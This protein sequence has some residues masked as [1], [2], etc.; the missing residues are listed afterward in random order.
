ME[1]NTKNRGF[2][3]TKWVRIP[4]AGTIEIMDYKFCP[5]C[6]DNLKIKSIDSEQ[7]PV[8]ESCGFVFYQ[9]SKPTASA[10][11]INDKN[12]AL[13]LKRSINPGKGLWD[14]MGGFLRNGEDPVTGLKR[15][16]SEELG[17]TPEVGPIVGIY[18][19]DYQFNGMAYKTINIYYLVRIKQEKINLSSE[20]SEYKWFETNEIPFGKMAFKQNDQILKDYLGR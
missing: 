14:I 2:L 12:Q 5:K 7:L 6:G 15:E 19:D 8:C 9:N 20:N 18:M 1:E 16:F 11:I 3:G 17:F 4:T 10:L 13:L